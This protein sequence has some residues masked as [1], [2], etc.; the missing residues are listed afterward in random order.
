MAWYSFSM[1]LLSML[2]IINSWVYWDCYT[3]YLFSLLPMWTIRFH[4]GGLI[5]FACHLSFRLFGEFCT[6]WHPLKV[7]VSGY[8]CV[9]KWLDDH[10][11][12]TSQLLLSSIV[13]WEMIMDIFQTLKFIVFSFH[14][15]FFLSRN[16]CTLVPFCRYEPPWSLLWSQS[17]FTTVPSTSR[18]M[19][20]LV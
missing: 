15:P 7:L 3:I 13:V 14:F 18:F 9:I 12:K 16:W 20:H 2:A 11:S 17:P 6:I 1:I 8:Q 4:F 10:S 19:L 5:T